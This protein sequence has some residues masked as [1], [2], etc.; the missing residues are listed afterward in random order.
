MPTK[1]EKEITKVR[2]EDLTPELQ[3]RFDTLITKS[4]FDDL[5]NRLNAAQALLGK[6]RV[7][8]GYDYPDDAKPMKDMFYN[9]S[10]LVPYMFSDD[11]TWHPTQM[12]PQGPPGKVKI[13]I[14]IIQSPHQTITVTIYNLDSSVR[15]MYE[16]R[17]GMKRE[18]TKHEIQKVLEA[19]NKTIEEEKK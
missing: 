18:L 6:N 8:I 11:G 12:V 17:D 16:M 10:T 7:R 1:E 3:K 4:Q 5:K 15:T 9:A 14:K 2:Y 13:N 19:K